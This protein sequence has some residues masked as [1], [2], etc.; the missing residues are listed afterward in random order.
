MDLFGPCTNCSLSISVFV[1]TFGVYD[2][3]EAT[4]WGISSLMSGAALWG[5]VRS[6][7]HEMALRLNLHTVDV[8]RGTDAELIS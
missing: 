7:R 3:V 4:P 6:V 1:V 8:A 5:L 2:V